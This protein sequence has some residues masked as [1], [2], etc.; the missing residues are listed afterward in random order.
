MPEWKRLE[1]TKCQDHTKQLC[2]LF[3]EVRGNRSAGNFSTRGLKVKLWRMLKKLKYHSPIW[4]LISD[5]RCKFVTY[6]GGLLSALPFFP[7]FSEGNY[8]EQFFCFTYRFWLGEKKSEKMTPKTKGTS[9]QPWEEKEVKNSFIASNNFDLCSRLR[10]AS[11]SADLRNS[12]ALW[13]DSER[14]I[15]GILCIMTQYYLVL[16]SHNQ[17]DDPG[18]QRYLTR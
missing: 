16:H 15:A 5:E 14:F 1:E 3:C 7:H 18:K 6:A 4:V 17:M 2:F 12:G 11:I 8:W 9:W 13:E 10:K